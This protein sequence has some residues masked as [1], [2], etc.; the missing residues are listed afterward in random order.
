MF[1]NLI[2]RNS[3]RNRKDNGL[4]FSCL[5]ISVIAFYIILSIS[6]QD[7]MIFLRKMESDAVNKLLLM[8]PVFYIMTLVILFFLIYFACKY[9]LQ[10]RLHEFG[11]YLMMGMRQSRLFLMLLAEDLAGSIWALAVG[12]PA[13]VFLSEL[14]SL[15]TARLVGMGIIGHQFMLSVP[16][17][18]FT[19]GGFL[20]IKLCAFLILS[21]KICRQE[22]GS[23]LADISPVNTIN[24]KKQR[25][26]FFY[27]VCALGGI[28]M[29][30]AAYAFGIQG[31]AWQTQR[32]MLF[33]LCLGLIGTIVL[34]YGMRA[35]ISLV[36]F[37][38]R[39]GKKLHIFNFR[40]IQENVI[41]QST[42]LA[43]SS[44][45]ILAA[46]C[47]LGAGMGIA[48]GSQK[49]NTHVIDYTFRDYSSGDS[50][51]VYSRVT[52]VLKENHLDEHFSKI[53]PVRIGNIR[54]S[55]K[56]ENVFIMDTV[57]DSLGSLPESEDRDILLNNLSYA[58][59]PYVIC[60]SDYNMLLE[61]AGKPEL[62]L[63]PDEAGIY[64]D[65]ESINDN[66]T[67]ILNDILSS[68]PRTLL[69]GKEFFLTGTVQSLNFVTDDAITLSFA[70]ILPDEQF[71][72]YTENEYSVYVNGI[73]SRDIT[74]KTGLMNAYS[75]LNEK[76]DVIGLSDYNIEYESYLQNIGRQLFYMVSASYITIYLAVI[77]FV[78]SNTI[79]GVQ[80][81]MNQRKTGR[82]YQTLVKLGADY[83]TLCQSS[84][85]QINWFMGLPVAV[86]AISSMFGI[87][88]LF[89]GI[90]SYDIRS[91]Q[92]QLYLISVT[93]ILF[94]SVIEYIYIT[95][96]KKSSKRY[97]LTVMQPRRE[98]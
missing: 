83:E 70:L 17:L 36:I 45:L 5:I 67:A 40:Q 55:Q 31:I 64:C 89:S 20:M 61:M 54:T 93:V 72:Y 74:E 43:I 59:N 33:T 29:L 38:G 4:F 15:V 9:Q 84:R 68:H 80:F 62:S 26:S 11:V 90:L 35:L 98:E 87:K 21:V 44:L 13:A 49:M 25:P 97:L 92:G 86:A 22:I 34:F 16:A 46:L 71:Y 52:E 6:Q 27:G 85:K 81:L 2:F 88:A 82:R 47:C 69:D 28:A 63:G 7:V 94:L 75:L 91:T 39:S 58:D 30:A 66:R 8:I 79:M 3:K 53:F 65:F 18:I 76:L 51:Q 10:R 50:T 32:M 12:L 23:M 42:S 41:L 56:S 14:I 48:V 96:I 24:K 78:V 95:I 77:F 73:L 37:S 60:L 1:F 57:M 19:I